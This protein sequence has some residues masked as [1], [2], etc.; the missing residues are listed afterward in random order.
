MKWVHTYSKTKSQL[1]TRNSKL[2]LVKVFPT[3]NFG[4]NHFKE[5][6]AVGSRKLSSF[7]VCVE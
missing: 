5:L 7:E 3:R 1:L 6:R 2:H 4:N